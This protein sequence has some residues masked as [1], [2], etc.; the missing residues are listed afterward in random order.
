MTAPSRGAL[1]P[2][3]RRVT[4]A[5]GATDANLDRFDPAIVAVESGQIHVDTTPGTE[6]LAPMAN[7]ILAPGNTLVITETMDLDIS[8]PTDAPAVILLLSLAQLVQMAT[9]VSPITADDGIDVWGLAGNGTVAAIASTG[10]LTAEM[11]EITL[12]PGTRLSTHETGLTEF[13]VVE[14][15]TLTAVVD[16][17]SVTAWLLDPRGRQTAPGSNVALA[18]GFGLSVSGA[19]AT[20][21]YRNESSDPVTFLLVTLSIG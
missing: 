20:T 2:Y 14:A 10:R 9:N 19:G 7:Q 17:Q 4:F 12:A 6:G 21:S 11:A 8:N 13:V 1:L 18:Q 16:G 15:G 5:P 3:L